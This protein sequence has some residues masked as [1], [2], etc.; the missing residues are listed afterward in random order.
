MIVE[1]KRTDTYIPEWNDNKELPETEQIKFL[2]KFLGAADRKQYVYN[3]PIEFS[4]SKDID[5]V[6]KLE[7]VTDGQ[8]IA[9]KCV[10]SIENLSVNIDGKTT[11]I[12]DIATFY[13][14]AFSDLAAEL[15]A[16]MLECTAVV[17]LKN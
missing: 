15:E 2:H 7:I 5:Q 9:R 3:K 17:D 11:A 6:S 4:Q 1:L 12:E 13:K 8:G 14:Y 10:T 16:Y